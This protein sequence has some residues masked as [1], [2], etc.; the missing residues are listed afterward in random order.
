MAFGIFRMKLQAF[1][2]Q[3]F[4]LCFMVTFLNVSMI[5]Q[6]KKKFYSFIESALTGKP[7]SL[8]F[9]AINSVICTPS[10]Q[11]FIHSCLTDTFPV[12]G[13]FSLL[14]TK[15]FAC[16]HITSSVYKSSSSAQ[17][18]TQSVISVLKHTLKSTP[19]T[20][21]VVLLPADAVLKLDTWVPPTVGPA[22]RTRG[23]PG[24]LPPPH[25][26]D[27]SGHHWC[28]CSVDW[29]WWNGSQRESPNLAPPLVA[30][31]IF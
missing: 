20:C 8:Q 7:V 13:L 31:N 1:K 11:I 12:F 29:Q 3:E 27:G 16:V 24:D 15:Y 10:T 4:P 26:P 19:D 17:I 21:K 30:G 18:C 23:P 2:T 28:R 22:V 25:M 9:I 6:R 14:G 5:L